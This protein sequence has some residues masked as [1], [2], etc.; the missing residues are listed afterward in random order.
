MKSKKDKENAR[1]RELELRATESLDEKLKRCAAKEWDGVK[2]QHSIKPG[3]FGDPVIRKL[4]SDRLACN[5]E[6]DI[7][8][9]PQPKDEVD[10]FDPTT[11][12]G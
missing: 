9:I 2:N 4:R 6:N 8:V 3:R 12:G 10:P 5:P 7:I 1:K 11:Y